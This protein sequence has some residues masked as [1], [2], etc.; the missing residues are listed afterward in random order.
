MDFSWILQRFYKG[1]IHGFAQN[2]QFV[3]PPIYLST[4]NEAYSLFRTTAGRRDKKNATTAAVD[5]WRFHGWRLW[6]LRECN[7]KLL[8]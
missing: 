6:R 1:D 8:P 5:G 2:L 3:K 7:A 4:V